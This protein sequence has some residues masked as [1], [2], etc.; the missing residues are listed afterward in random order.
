[1]GHEFTKAFVLGNDI[2]TGALRGEEPGDA[3]EALPPRRLR[4]MRHNRMS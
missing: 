2:Q 4:I 3:K 1:M